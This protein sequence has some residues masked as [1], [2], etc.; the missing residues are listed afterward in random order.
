MTDDK[1]HIGCNVCERN[2]TW[3]AAW[4]GTY[5]IHL[6]ILQMVDYLY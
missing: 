1:Y 2:I 3:I 4:K 5:V 6:F